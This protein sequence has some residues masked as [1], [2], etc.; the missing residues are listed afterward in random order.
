MNEWMNHHWE[1]GLRQEMCEEYP[2]FLASFSTR[3]CRSDYR[4]IIPTHYYLLFLSIRPYR[5]FKCEYV[6]YGK[7]QI[8]THS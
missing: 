7:F 5:N 1:F 3:E 4:V 6:K 8:T 2:G